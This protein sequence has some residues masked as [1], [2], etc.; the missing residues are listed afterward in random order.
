[1]VTDE[2]SCDTYIRR[3]WPSRSTLDLERRLKRRWELDVYQACEGLPMPISDTY[4]FVLRL[5]ASVANPK[6]QPVCAVVCGRVFAPN[7]AC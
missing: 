6:H 7:R 3:N 4:L 5:F 1:M 2:K